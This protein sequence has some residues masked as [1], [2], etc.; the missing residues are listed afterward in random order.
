MG[1]RQWGTAAEARQN[2]PRS[3]IRLEREDKEPAYRHRHDSKQHKVLNHVAAFVHG[4]LPAGAVRPIRFPVHD[5]SFPRGRT[6]IRTENVLAVTVFLVSERWM[7][8]PM[9]W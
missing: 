9:V 8:S 6:R 7:T 4:V 1:E 3:R 2:A 5:M